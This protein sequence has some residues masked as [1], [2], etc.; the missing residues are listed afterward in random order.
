LHAAFGTL[1]SS[2]GAGESSG[3]GTGSVGGGG[4]TRTTAFAGFAAFGVVFELLVVKEKL[5]SG[6]K[7]KFPVT[8]GTGK[9]AVYEL[10]FHIT[11]PV[12]RKRMIT[13]RPGECGS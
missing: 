10:G 9:N 8:V 13:L 7:N 11:S 1:G 4:E 12:L 3:S 2:F 6:C 5:F